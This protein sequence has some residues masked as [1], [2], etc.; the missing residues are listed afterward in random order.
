M[1]V[2][3]GEGRQHINMRRHIPSVYFP[4]IVRENRENEIGVTDS[5]RDIFS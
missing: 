5:E 2:R 1:D 4:C 3:N